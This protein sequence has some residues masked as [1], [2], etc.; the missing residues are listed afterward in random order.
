MHIILEFDV[1]SASRL[2]TVEHEHEHEHDHDPPPFT[3]EKQTAL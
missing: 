3:M 2:A 1:P